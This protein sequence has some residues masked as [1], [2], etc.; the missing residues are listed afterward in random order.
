MLKYFFT[1]ITISLFAI[2]SSYAQ[3][4]PMAPKN[5]SV[6]GI[7]LTGMYGYQYG[8]SLDHYKGKL[9]IMDSDNMFFSV[10]LP[11]R[12]GMMVELSYLRQNTSLSLKEYGTNITSRLTDLALEYYQI[13]T[14]KGIPMGKVVP[15]GQFSL[16]ATRFHAGNTQY[17]DTW[18]FSITLGLGAKIHINDRFGLRLQAN[19]LIPMR[20]SGAGFWFGTGGA[21]AGIT[22]DGFFQGNVMGGI[23]FKI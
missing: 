6:R 22:A 21:S 20:F 1:L 13:G 9:D 16:G 3:L 12:Y 17:S 14:I 10:A 23:F 11:I 18:T 19:M 4:K 2:S 15:F 5:S 7:E 8:G